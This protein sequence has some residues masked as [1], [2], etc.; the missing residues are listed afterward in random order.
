MFNHINFLEKK[1]CDHTSFE[2]E[3][4]YKLKI[5]M[6]YNNRNIQCRNGDTLPNFWS[7]I[8]KD[9]I[10]KLYL[11]QGLNTTW[12]TTKFWENNVIYTNEPS[13]DRCRII[14]IHV[15]L[16]GVAQLGHVANEVCDL[17]DFYRNQTCYDSCDLID[18]VLIT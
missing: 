1:Q 2:L 5:S 17:E 12:T 14:N 6:I 10:N 7:N 15:S 4:R 11:G 18:R 9:I 16:L 8:T 3:I 13:I